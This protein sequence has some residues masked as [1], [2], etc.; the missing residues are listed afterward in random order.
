MNSKACLACRCC[1]RTTRS[2]HAMFHSIFS[3]DMQGQKGNKLPTIGTTTLNIA[4]LASRMETQVETKLPITLQVAGVASEASLLVLIS[5][6]E[7]KSSSYSKEPL[8]I[9]HDE[10]MVDKD[11]G[12]LRKMMDLTGYVSKNKKKKTYAEKSRKGSKIYSGE[13]TDDSSTFDS[14]ISPGNDSGSIEQELGQMDHLSKQCAM[15]ATG[16]EPS[17]YYRENSMTKVQLGPS[18]SS[19]TQLDSVPKFGFLSWKKR[20]LSMRR[21]DEPLIRKTKRDETVDLAKT[22]EKLSRGSSHRSECNNHGLS[23]DGWEERELISRDGLAKL[24]AS[25]FFASIDQ[26]SE[27]ASGESACAALVAVIA[28]WLLSNR[29]ALP[30][31]DEFNTLIT[32]G[33]SE[34][35]N[36]CE[37][38][39]YMQRFPDKHFDLETVLEADLRPLS[40][41]PDRSFIG[42][43]S[44]EK[45]ESLKGHI[46]F[47]SIWDMI[48][49]SINDGEHQV[50]MVSWNDHFFIL[51]IE[52][53]ACYIIDTLGERLFEGCSQAYILKFDDASSIYGLPKEDRNDRDSNN[54]E[55]THELVYRGKECCRE[56]IKRFLAAIPLKELEVEEKKGRSV[57]GLSLYRRL[58]IEFHFSST[59]SASSSSSSS[60]DEAEDGFFQ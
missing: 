50:Y 45:F 17:A 43:F 1:R 21:K 55:N 56:F 27:K 44:P 58:Q 23:I 11:D 9:T 8:E 35:R 42:F 25:V 20:K 5:F 13:T 57:S 49:G 4:E 33:S 7:I 32:E 53:N 29:G 52:S 18:L 47:D 19:K 51:K 59:T 37:K 6:V 22:S 2:T 60:S 14:N 15:V 12:F 34:W 46:S 40:I 54:G 48:S 39:D 3:F 36:L 28:D 30:T 26:R 10:C 16:D 38:E 31:K 24:K 41:M